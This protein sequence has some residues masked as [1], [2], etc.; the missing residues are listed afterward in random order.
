MTVLDLQRRLAALGF[1]V[2]P[3][4]GLLGPQTLRAA[5]DALPK[6]EGAPESSVAVSEAVPTDWMPWAKMDRIIVHWTAG[7][8]KAS[9]FD[10]KHYHILIEGDGKLVR[11]IPSI[12]LNSAPVKPGYAAHCLNCN[13]GSIGVSLCGM[14]GSV[15]SPFNAGEQPITRA[16]WTAL[17]GVLADLCRRYAIPVTPG[18]VLSHA[19]VQA[20]LGIKQ[21]N[22]WDIARL[23]WNAAARSAR[24]IGDDFRAAA[25]H[26]L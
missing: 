12:A 21:R 4:D 1:D 17:A 9:A 5:L 6:P 18:T 25:A 20:T 8:N 26:R 11:G 24:A 10:R 2:G 14:A 16:Q 15:E 3:L 13:S 7:G 19:E 23:P 22:K